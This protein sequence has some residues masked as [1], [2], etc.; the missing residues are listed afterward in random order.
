MARGRPVVV[1]G[2]RAALAVFAHRPDAILSAFHA[3]D[4]RRALGPLLSALARRRRPYEE[5]DDATLERLARSVHHEGV[6]LHTAPLPAVSL[7]E[8]VRGLA[9]DAVLLALDGV[10]N[11]HNLGAILRSAA[12][13]GAAG[14]VVAQAG[15]AGDGQ[16]ALGGAAMRVAQGAAE[17]VPVAWV[18]DLEAALGELTR[19]GVTLA[20][21]EAD[22][23]ASPFEL[24]LPRPLCLVLGNE[25]EGIRPRLRARCAHLLSV[26]GTGAVESLNVSVAA[27][28][29]LAAACARPARANLPA[30]EA[31][32]G[33]APA[34]EPA[35]VWT[36]RRGRARPGPGAEGAAPDGPPARSQRGRRAARG[37]RGRASEAPEPGPEAGPA[38]DSSGDPTG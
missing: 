20:A 28:V 15:G 14:V 11:P 35:R 32:T 1:F 12:W 29:L 21:A 24:A 2:L 9:P 5:V 10:G 16:G 3:P 37:G 36:E 26:P 38:G 17:V 7:R 30:P 34:P 18:P 6:V 27:G 19:A 13:F 4:R 31:P 33:D 23:G 25:E 22:G 8:L